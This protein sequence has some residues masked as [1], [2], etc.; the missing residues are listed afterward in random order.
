MPEVIGDAGLLVS[1]HDVDAIVQA[2]EAIVFD[3]D[4]AARLRDRAFER[5]RIFSWKKHV[6]TLL[7]CYRTSTGQSHC[8][9]ATNA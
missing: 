5:S 7:Q 1:P 2:I 8:S 9:N 4:A 6:D 3:P